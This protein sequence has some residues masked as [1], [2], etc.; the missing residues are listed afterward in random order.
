[1]GR[2]D[3]GRS[4]GFDRLAA[5]KGAENRWNSAKAYGGAFPSTRRFASI[6]I[7]RNRRA[8]QR[9][10]RPSRAR[11]NGVLEFRTASTPRRSWIAHGV[12][13]ECSWSAHGADRG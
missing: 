1:M 4:L 13:M 11:F 5:R 12:L 7:L 10:G 3:T 6:D 8:V 9:E 2:D